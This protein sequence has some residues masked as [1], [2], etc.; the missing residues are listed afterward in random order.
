MD[1]QFGARPQPVGGQFIGASPHAIGD[2]VTGDDQVLA[3][4]V[5]ATQDDMGVGVI[6]VPVVH[7]HP[8]QLGTQVLF[9][10]LH[11]VAG[12]AV[13]VFQVRRILGRD[14]EAELVAILLTALL[15]ISQIGII[16]QSA[17]GPSRFSIPAHPFALDIA[18]VGDRGTR[19]GLGEPAGS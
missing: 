10:P 12:I 16:T 8:V 19:P 6:G 9:H 14:N 17:V 2:V 15:E 13:Q 3:P 7:R 1:L 18:Q 5:L 11:Q 4:V